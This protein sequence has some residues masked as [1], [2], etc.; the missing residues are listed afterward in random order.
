M[1]FEWDEAKSERI[2]RL[3][4]FGFAEASRIFEGFTLEWSDIREDWGE[5]GSSPLVRSRA[6]C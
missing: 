4:G 5:A 2:R 6:L 3:R 1:E